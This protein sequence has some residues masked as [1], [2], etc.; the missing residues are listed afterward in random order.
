MKKQR[1]LII[2]AGRMAEAIIEGVL[3]RE[4]DQFELIVTNSGNK[5]KLRKLSDKFNIQTELDWYKIVS[6]VDVILIAAPPNV[7][8]ELLKQLSTLISDQLI[9]TI[10]AG[11]DP[12]YLQARLPKGTPVCWMMPNTAAK[13][14][15]SMTT[16]VCGAHVTDSHREIIHCILNSIGESEELSEEEV[17]DLTAITGSAPAFLYTFV[18]ALVESSKTYGI[19]EEQA[20]NLVINMVSG[21]AKM[22]QTEGT[23]SELKDQV[24]TPGGST[25]AGLDILSQ[26]HFKEILKKAVEA[27]NAHA[28]K[29]HNK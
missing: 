27:T 16:Y 17:H 9:V 24:T 29:S 6:K 13:V 8:E 26:H 20:R 15:K 18:E 21:S 12:T 4:S 22:L 3:V 28:R 1:M 7:H 5:Q 23:P 14:Q 19:K 10:A 25:A 11:I 2:G